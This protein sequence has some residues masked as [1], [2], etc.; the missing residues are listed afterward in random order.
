[1][2]K[3]RPSSTRPAAG[4]IAVFTK[5]GRALVFAIDE[6]RQFQGP[7]PQA[8]RRGPGKTAL[9]EI[10]PV[11]DGVAGKLKGERLESCRGNRGGKGKPVKRATQVSALRLAK[12]KKP[13][14]WASAFDKTC[15]NQAPAGSLVPDIHFLVFPFL[16][17]IGNQA[18][19]FV[20]IRLVMVF[21]R[22]MFD[23]F[24]DRFGLV[25]GV[26]VGHGN[27]SKK[28]PLGSPRAF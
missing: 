7:R 11:I 15:R 25:V 19:L 21:F 23:G 24:V 27:S 1:M 5:D 16:D 8:D 20:G 12:T 17:G 3:H 6:I 18:G 13:R 28:K 10:L 14:S 2:A 4:E 26:R 9:D 22:E